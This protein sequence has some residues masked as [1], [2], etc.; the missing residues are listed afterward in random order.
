MNGPGPKIVY[1]PLVVKRDIPRLD[2][3]VRS[4]IKKAI[5]NK[6]TTAP[7]I[8]GLPLRG[9]LKGYWKLRV[10]DWRVAYEITG[11]IVKIW[12][13]AH[14]REVYDLVAQRIG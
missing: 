3:S 5:Q 7:E 6:L 14:R 9:T 12:V 1:H 11:K 2:Q 8:Y 4:V 13:I 10:G